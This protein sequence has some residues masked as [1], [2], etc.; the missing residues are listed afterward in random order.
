M[1]ILVILVILVRIGRS[2][3]FGLSLKSR[4]FKLLPR[5]TML[6]RCIELKIADLDDRIWGLRKAGSEEVKYFIGT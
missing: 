3:A 2:G 4:G 6:W 5:E 1:M